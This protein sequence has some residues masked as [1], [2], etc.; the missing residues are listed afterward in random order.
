[1]TLI[2]RTGLV[3]LIHWYDVMTL[4]PLRT[5]LV[6]LIHWY[7]VMT[8]IPLRTGLVTL[9]HRYSM[10]TLIPQKYSGDIDSQNRSGDFDLQT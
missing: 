10:M 9:I 2:R 4:I 7:D 6:T 5:G 8:L 3:T 1:M